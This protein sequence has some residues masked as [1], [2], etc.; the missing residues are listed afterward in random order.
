MP[1]NATLSRLGERVSSAPHHAS[2]AR[3][4]MH[5]SKWVFRVQQAVVPKPEPA[6][7]DNSLHPPFTFHLQLINTAYCLAETT[8]AAWS[9]TAGRH[10]YRR[11]CKETY[12]FVHM[13]TQTHATTR[14][15]CDVNDCI[16]CPQGV[17]HQGKGDHVCAHWLTN[18][19]RNTISLHKHKID[20]ALHIIVCTKSNAH[21]N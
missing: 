16:C 1:T 15:K 21:K 10:E 8:Q 17:K 14:T 6:S 3:E 13:Q 9:S 18:S 19:L 7:G 12:V 5:L 4:E 20:F 11:T 2:T